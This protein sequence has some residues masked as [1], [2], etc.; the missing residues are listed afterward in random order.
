MKVS[1]R[2]FAQLLGHGQRTVVT[3][4]Q[5]RT[6]P[7][8]ALVRA[9]I[10]KHLDSGGERIIPLDAYSDFALVSEIMRRL[11]T[12]GHQTEQSQK[13]RGEVCN[14]MEQSITADISDLRFSELAPA[15]R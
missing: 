3:W 5:R 12:R 4:E 9:R 15:R 13:T 14:P 7:E 2:E 1:Q 10:C 6:R 8:G 11:E